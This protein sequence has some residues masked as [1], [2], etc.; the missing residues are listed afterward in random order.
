MRAPVRCGGLAAGFVLLVCDEEH[1]PAEHDC[2]AYEEH[3]AVDSVADHA[4]RGFALGDAEDDGSEE[5]EEHNRGK[6][7]GPEH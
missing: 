2:R 6:V 1:Y 4:A 7:R 5:R 3:K